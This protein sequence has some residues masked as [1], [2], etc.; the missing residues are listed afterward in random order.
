MVQGS[1][2]RIYAPLNHVA[3]A[4]SEIYACGKNLGFY[5]QEAWLPVYLKVRNGW[6]LQSDIYA[7]QLARLR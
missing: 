5:N 1:I 7:K 4:V 3:Q 2:N 6:V